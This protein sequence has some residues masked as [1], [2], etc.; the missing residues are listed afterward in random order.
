MA[1]LFWVDFGL[2]ALGRRAVTAALVADPMKAKF[3]A[4]PGASEV[5]KADHRPGIMVAI[6]NRLA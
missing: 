6:A 3:C 4:P 5:G 1:A 2:D